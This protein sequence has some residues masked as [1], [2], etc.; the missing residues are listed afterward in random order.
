M[1]VA[2][3]TWIAETQFPHWGWTCPHCVCYQIELPNWTPEA[4][5]HVACVDC[6]K[7]FYI[8]ET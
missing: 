6:D 7:S 1:K 3:F 8:E 2:D 4:G 5:D